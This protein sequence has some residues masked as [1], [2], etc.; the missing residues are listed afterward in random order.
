ME[1]S[2]WVFLTLTPLVGVRFQRLFFIL[3]LTLVLVLV[4]S[5]FELFIC[6]IGLDVIPV[7]VVALINV[8]QHVGIG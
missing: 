4:E 2:S 1:S 3:N 5:N 6:A 8:L 7:D